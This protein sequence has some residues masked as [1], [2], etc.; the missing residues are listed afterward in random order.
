MGKHDLPW[1][2]FFPRDWSGDPNLKICSRKARGFLMD[3]LCVMHECDPRGRL[4]TGERVW[5]DKEIALSTNG[6]I[7]ESLKCLQELV[8]KGVLSRDESG[9]ICSRRMI[10]DEIERERW[11]NSKRNSQG[12]PKE[13]RANSA[14]FPP[15][16]S[17]S[18]SDIR[19]SPAAIASESSELVGGDV[20]KFAQPK[21][22][23]PKRKPDPI[24]DA[25]AAEWFEG[26]VIKR[27]ASRV[28]KLVSDLKELGA[29]PEAIR[30][31][32]AVARQTWTIPAKPEAIVNNW[33][34]LGELAL[35][36]PTQPTIPHWRPPTEAEAEAERKRAEEWRQRDAEAAAKRKQKSG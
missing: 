24:W 15:V 26:L 7:Q 11:R 31:R 1:F 4:K 23:K 13:F 12:I 30:Q 22:V 34:Q 25:V 8:D 27:Q 18:E 29:T 3:L 28:G 21:P 36:P 2:Q 10:R 14:G 20:V 6:P 33:T 5:S 17:E 32:A 9:A 19:H 16:E 35:P